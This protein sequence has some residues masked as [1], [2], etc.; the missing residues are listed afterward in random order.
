MTL[1]A[2]L[3]DAARTAAMA[4]FLAAAGCAPEVNRGPIDFKP[5]PRGEA[6][7]RVIRVHEAAAVSPANGY[8]AVIQ[9]GSTWRHAGTT[10]KGEVYRPVGAVFVVEGANTH[11]AYLVI[12][13]GLL[14]GFYLPGE[15]AFSPAPQQV[16][17]HIEEGEVTR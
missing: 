2:N 8:G 16:P 6:P 9:A 14:V 1:T 3:R 17:L 10:P 15:S 4:L 5:L 13:D 11:E 7:A 12:A